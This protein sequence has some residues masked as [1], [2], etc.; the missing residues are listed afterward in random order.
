MPAW[1]ALELEGFVA[2]LCIAFDAISIRKTTFAKPWKNFKQELTVF[3][4][5]LAL[6]ICEE[7]AKNTQRMSTLIHKEFY[8]NNYCKGSH[9]EKKYGQGMTDPTT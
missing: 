1:Y 7:L 2:I 8:D 5:L 6:K 3:N 9:H 4:D